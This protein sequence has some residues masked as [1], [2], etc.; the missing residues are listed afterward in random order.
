[1][2]GVVNV[3]DGGP[4]RQFLPCRLASG[5]LVERPAKVYLRVLATTKRQL[6]DIVVGMLAHVV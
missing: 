6:P 3:V 4:R 5:Y 2:L 1:M